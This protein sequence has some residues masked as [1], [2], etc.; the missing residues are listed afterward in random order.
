[1]D[2][3]GVVA[4]VGGVAA[5]EE[6]VESCNVDEVAEVKEEVVVVVAVAVALLTVEEVLLCGVDGPKVVD[7][8]AVGRL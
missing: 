3:V 6:V 1:M 5:A 4:V 2:E 8:P 7:G